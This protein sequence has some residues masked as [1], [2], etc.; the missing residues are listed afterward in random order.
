MMSCTHA[1]AGILLA[2]LLPQALPAQTT[3]T[4][5]VVA[6][7][8][9][10]IGSGVG[11]ASVTIRNAVTGA[12]L[13]QGVQQGGT[14]DTRRIMAEPR[15]RGAIVYD[16]EGAAGFTATIALDT[17]TVVEVAAEGPLNYPQ[18]MRRASLTTLLVP[19]QDVTGDGIVLELHGFIVE[20]LEPQEARAAASLPVRARIRMVCGCPFTAGGMWDAGRM[21]V[22]ARIYDGARAV[23]EA[24]LAFTGE[25]NVW[26]GTIPA[27]GLPTGARLV[28]IA[29]DAGRANF[30]RSDVRVVF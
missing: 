25:E 10:L 3:V 28:V 30:G 27:A 26:A 24:P 6:H 29:A 18:A 12:V 5:R 19:G 4:V 22:T 23:R 7:D 20:L 14:G 17:P 8:A 21:S 11:G 1:Y 13:A 16:A 2:A 9:K 15:A